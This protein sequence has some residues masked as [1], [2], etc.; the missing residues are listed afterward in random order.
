MEKRHF[1]FAVLA[2]AAAL[3]V[4]NA[5]V[6][7]VRTLQ[8]EVKVV[9]ATANQNESTIVQFGA[10]CAGFYINGG[11][12]DT[13]GDDGLLPEAGTNDQ[14]KIADT[15]SGW[16]GVS[17]ELGDKACEWTNTTSGNTNT[18]YSTAKVYINVSQGKWY[19]KDILGFGYP[20]DFSPSPIYVTLVVSEPLD[21]ANIADAKLK[22]YNATDGSLLFEMDLKT[23]S[24]SGVQM[25]YDGNGYRIDL[26]L[27]ATG[28][29]SLDTFTIDFYVATENEQP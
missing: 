2:L 17:V 7:A 5:T 11:T 14:S 26:E 23:A 27:K 10:A 28:A 16:Y 12:Q 4:V 20:K 1:I 8:G 3:A 24:T 29:V 25:L 18:L 9:D 19:F 15:S 6:F 21:D 22:I 13:I